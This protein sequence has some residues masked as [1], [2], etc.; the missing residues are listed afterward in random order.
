M[1][2]FWFQKHMFTKHSENWWREAKYIFYNS[3]GS[4]DPVIENSFFLA[5]LMLS[6]IN[7]NEILA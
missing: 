5:L 6:K 3:T 1:S 7:F 2:I 4:A